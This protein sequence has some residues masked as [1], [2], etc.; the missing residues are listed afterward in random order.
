MKPVLTTTLSLLTVA[1]FTTATFAQGRHDE[2]PHGTMKSAPNTSEQSRAS[3]SGGRHDEG[4]TTHGKKKP[5]AKKDKS[6]AQ[7]TAKDK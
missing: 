1:V 7:D 3:G 5:A 2:K 4:S 6:S